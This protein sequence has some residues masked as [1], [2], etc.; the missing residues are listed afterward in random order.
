MD[1][2]GL[3]HLSGSFLTACADNL[4][5]QEKDDVA[6]SL[7]E[8]LAFLQSHAVNLGGEVKP[9]NI[10]ITKSSSTG[11]HAVFVAQPPTRNSGSKEESITKLADLLEFVWTSG[12]VKLRLTFAQEA[13][14][15]DM[16]KEDT[17]TM[18]LNKLSQHVAFW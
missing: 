2:R 12:E 3:R 17:N 7:V 6:R 14:L 8:G 1:K 16:R 5:N 13:V 18:S 15:S 10:F 9:G 11:C 4:T